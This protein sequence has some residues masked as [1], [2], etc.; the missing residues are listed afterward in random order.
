V[1]PLTADA[2][3]A[4]HASAHCLH[5]SAF[6]LLAAAVYVL[7]ELSRRLTLAMQEAHGKSVTGMKAKM[8]DLAKSLGL[9]NPAALTGGGGM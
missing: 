7:Q 2:G 6:L 9:P 4:S 1:L 8:Q 3:H 5:P